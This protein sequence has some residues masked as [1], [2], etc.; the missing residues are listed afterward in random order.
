MMGRWMDYARAQQQHPDLTFPVVPITVQT[1]RLAAEAA[2][3]SIDLAKP[4]VAAWWRWWAEARGE[5]GLRVVRG[6]PWSQG[7]E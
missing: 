7:A 5:D 3:R 1:D 6:R 2:A 4:G